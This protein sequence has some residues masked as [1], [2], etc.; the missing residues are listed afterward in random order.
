[1]Y[2]NTD[3]SNNPVTRTANQ[4]RKEQVEGIYVPKAKRVA[5][6]MEIQKA[7]FVLGHENS[8][9]IKEYL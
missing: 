9:S 7:H 5:A 1:M 3:V 6:K 2:L 4:L 8:K